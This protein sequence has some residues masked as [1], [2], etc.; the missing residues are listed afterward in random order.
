MSR[1]LYADVDGTLVGPGGDLL[2]GG[3]TRGVEALLRA[4]QRGLIVVPVTGRGVTAVRELCRLLGL[5]RG[6]AEL[7]CLHVEGRDTHH[8]L[9]ELPFD[10]L[11]PVEAMES[12]GALETVLGLGGLHRPP[13]WNHSRVATIVLRGSADVAA[14]DAAL[15]GAGHDWCRLFDN[16]ELP[17]GDH[18]YH[19]APAGAGKAA[20]VRA[21][22][23]RHGVD[24]D[25]A[26]Y[27]G[28][29]ASD[30]AC[31]AEVARC[32]LVANADPSLDWTLRT[33]APYGDGVAEVVEALL[34][35][36]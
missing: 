1:V 21:D 34:S 29:A 14:A 26:A 19:L 18:A 31:A 8:E 35:G 5:P 10:G 30:L 6:L 16:G 24:R 15:A 25:D 3:S 36:S 32:W 27:V 23:R 11:S 12:D 28:D 22:R 13:W 9:G 4:R 20:G 2:W 7:G 33:K 17:G